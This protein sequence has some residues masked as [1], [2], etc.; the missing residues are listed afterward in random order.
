MKR[1]L[2]ILLTVSA[3]FAAAPH[4]AAADTCGVPDKGTIWVDFADGSVPFWQTFARPGVIAAA[5]NFIYPPQLRAAGAKTVYWDMN[6]R[7]R[8]GTPLEPYDPA[9]VINRANRLYSTAALSSGCTRPIIAEN[10]L[11]GANL[12]TPWTANNAAYRRNV[13]IY[14]QTLSSLGAH[15]VILVPSAPYTGD[16]AG[17][18]WRQLSTYA[19]VVRES[20]FGAPSIAKQGPIEGSRS[21]RM[22]FRKRVAELTS[23][24]LPASKL[25]LMLGFMTTRGSGGR[26]G[27][28][29]KSWLEVTK[30]Q[31]LAAKQVASEV[32]LRS[33]WS[34]GWA[35]WSAGE[36]NPDKPTAACVYLWARN[37]SLCNGPGAA[38]KGFNASLTQ[39]QLALPGGT[40]CTLYGKPVTESAISALRPITGDPDVAFSAAFARVVTTLQVPLKSKQI[41]DAERAVVAARFGGSFAAYRAALAK[42]HASIGAARA[43]IADELRRMQ[44]ERGFRVGGVSAADVREFYATYAQSLARLVQTKTRAPWLGNR[45]RGYALADDAPPQ[46]FSLPLG[47]KW[48]RVRTM[49]G[50]FQVKALDD[51]VPLGALPLD[52]ARQP[53]VDAL[54]TIARSDRYESWLMARERQLDD[55]AVCRRDVQP[56]PFFVDLTDY[57]PFLAAD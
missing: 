19:D 44:I 39:G 46:V 9:V 25:G 43:V 12:V 34:W 54:Q 32:G 30:L 4:R 1:L 21:L 11:N 55:Q 37:Q 41:S 17:D 38:G 33:I 56:D 50:T 36:T 24:G 35:T 47:G 31:A 57:L 29:R 42:A 40:R 2:V 53:V 3:G 20:Y 5:A 16:V 18:W 10:E 27:A 49:S 51:A 8:V 26:E 48:K 52:V 23:A 15:P 45:T 6:F 13:M 7:L 28:S 22:M 14:V